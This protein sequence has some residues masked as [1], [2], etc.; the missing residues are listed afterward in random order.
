MEAK[1]FKEKVG[2]PP[3]Q[4]AMDWEVYLDHAFYDMWAVRPVGDDDYNSSRLFHLPT[5][6]KAEQ[7][8]Q[9][10]TESNCAVPAQFA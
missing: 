3:E 9:L 2:R 6:E 4:E 5:K 10:L 7:L 1:E 8:Q